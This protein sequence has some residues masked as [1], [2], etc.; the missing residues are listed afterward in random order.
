[1]ISFNLYD[2]FQGQNCNNTILDLC[3]NHLQVDRRDLFDVSECRRAKKNIHS[4][5]V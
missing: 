1:M 4:L 5:L 3:A 2:G